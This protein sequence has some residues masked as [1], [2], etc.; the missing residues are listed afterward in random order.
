MR[1][2]G[3]RARL[4]AWAPVV[5]YMALIVALSS[6]HIDTGAMGSWPHKDKLAHLVEYAGLALLTVRASRLTWPTRPP[7]R[8]A[9]F[10]VMLTA[11]FGLT[12]ELHQAFV[13]GR[14]ADAWDLFADV[15]GAVLGVGLFF[16][17]DVLRRRALGTR[18]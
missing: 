15:L 7:A 14:T 18:P 6:F 5:A 16:A 10:A 4:V 1:A 9:A 11:S 17:P 3:F 12:D 8:V 13:P 2:P